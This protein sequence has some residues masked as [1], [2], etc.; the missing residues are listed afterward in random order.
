MQS[1]IQS[2]SVF[3]VGGGPVGLA[4]APSRARGT[5][6]GGASGST[7]GPFASA[8]GGAAESARVF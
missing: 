8:Q 6:R 1:D 5:L 4:M 7:A 3:I 2:T